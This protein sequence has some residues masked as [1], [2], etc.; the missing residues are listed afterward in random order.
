MLACCVPV[1]VEIL[2]GE[3]ILLIGEFTDKLDGT[4]VLMF[5][6]LLTGVDGLLRVLF[7][8]ALFAG[9]MLNRARMGEVSAVCLP[10]G[11]VGVVL[12]EGGLSCLLLLLES[13]W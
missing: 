4:D 2:G 8:V 7:P 9:G 5:I 3:M 1:G 12:R 6:N 11:G 10:A 13:G